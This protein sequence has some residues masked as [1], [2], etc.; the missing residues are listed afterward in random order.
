MATT[1][2]YNEVDVTEDWEY[3]I[4]EFKDSNKIGLAGE[5]TVHELLYDGITEKTINF[6]A[7][8]AFK[9]RALPY[10]TNKRSQKRGIDCVLEP[11]VP[12]IA[13]DIKTRTSKYNKCDDVA[14]ETWSMYEK[15]VKGWAWTSESDVILYGWFGDESMT[16]LSDLCFIRTAVL[17][18]RL[19][20]YYSTWKIKYEEKATPNGRAGVIKYNTLWIP[21][22]IKVLED[23]GVCSMATDVCGKNYS[24]LLRNS[25]DPRQKKQVGMERYMK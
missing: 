25:R 5:K 14:V 12:R 2:L 11:T 6:H 9:V 1:R 15:N 16:W 3:V 18:K 4:Y 13:I 17:K 21:V 22:P 7:G 20:K 23:L 19:E 8:R 24:D 10:E